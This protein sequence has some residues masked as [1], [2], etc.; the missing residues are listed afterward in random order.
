VAG[1]DIIVETNRA[2]RAITAV[3]HPVVAVVQGPVAGVGVSLALAYDVVL[4]SDKAFLC[5]PSSRWG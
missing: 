4:A 5:S 3:P 1:T 2:I